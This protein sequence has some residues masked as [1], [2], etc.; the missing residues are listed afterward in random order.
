[1]RVVAFARSVMGAGTTETDH[2]H[3]GAQLF[4]LLSNGI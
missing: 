1:M 2:F 4:R 3:L